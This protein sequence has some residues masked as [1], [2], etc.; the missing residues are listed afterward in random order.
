MK[1]LKLTSKSGSAIT[2]R[3]EKKN[4]TIKYVADISVPGITLRRDYPWVWS[5]E[6]GQKILVLGHR[7]SERMATMVDTE[8]ESRVN[9]F[10]LACRE[11][12]QEEKMKL[13]QPL[14][15]Q[16]PEREFS[17]TGNDEKAQELLE[18][19][20]Q[21]KNVKGPEM[22]GVNMSQTSRRQVLRQEAMKH[23]QHDIEES[24][25]YGYTGDARREVTR[26]ITC[27][28]CELVFVDRVSEE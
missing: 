25:Q 5:E 26:E 20:A 14:I 22:D 16:L 7:G 17:T 23:C 2:L 24:F 11:W 1:N 10:I 6:K 8:T 4:N 27:E 12:E 21:I 19:A 3:A 15:D 9:D 13:Y 18:Q 28:K